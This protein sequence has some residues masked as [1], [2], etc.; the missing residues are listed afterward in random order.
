MKNILILSAVLLTLASCGVNNKNNSTATDTTGT[1]TLA[2]KVLTAKMYINDTIKVGEPVQL[3]FTVYNTT[4]TVMQFCKWHTPFEPPMSKYLDI[5]NA[6]GEEVNYKGAMAK[7]IMPPPA[8][9][10]LELAAADSVT[11]Y[12]D[13]LRSYAI[14]KPARYTIVYNS[15][16]MSGL[17]VSDSVSF[18]YVK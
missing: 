3:K 12:A 9:S 18:V 1:D 7:R 11:T 10:Y 16:N 2:P 14:D 4:D 8:D 6:A 13:L 17:V 5:K 15:Q